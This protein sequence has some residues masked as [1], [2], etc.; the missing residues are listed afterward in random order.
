MVTA[1]EADFG[2]VGGS[3]QPPENRRG[4]NGTSHAHMTAR[5]CSSRAAAAASV[6]QP[7][8]VPTLHTAT[9]NCAMICSP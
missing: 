9:A 4:R 5:S 1:D 8:F 6:D 2:L 3:T 7:H